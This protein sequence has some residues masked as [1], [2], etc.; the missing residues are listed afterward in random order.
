[1]S[2][3]FVTGLTAVAYSGARHEVDQPHHLVVAD[4]GIC[5]TRCTEE[6]GNPCEHFCPAAVYEMIPDDDGSAKH[7]VIHHE[8][9]VHCKT[10]DIA[11]P[12]AIITWTTPEGFAPRDAELELAGHH[13]AR[14]HLGGRALPQLVRDVALSAKG[15][16]D[17]VGGEEE[18]HSAAEA[19][20]R[21]AKRRPLR[22]LQQPW[23][24]T[25]P[26]A[27]TRR[28]TMPPICVARC[29]LINLVEARDQLAGAGG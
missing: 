25:T 23:S 8:N 20:A 15:E 24:T 17:R 29:S 22:R 11:D 3:G 21:L 14:A 13:G 2:I 5:R 26:S 16:A 19:V 6:Y 7:R 9:C 10:C 18:A 1:M 28:V 27:S 4:T 12:Y